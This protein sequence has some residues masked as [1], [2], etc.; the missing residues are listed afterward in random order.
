MKKLLDIKPEERNKVTNLFFQNFFDGLGTSF[1]YAMGIFIFLGNSTHHDALH[2]YPLVFVIGGLLI[3]MVSPVYSKIETRRDPLVYHDELLDYKI[4]KNGNKT[5]EASRVKRM[6]LTA[7]Y[8][9][10]KS[11]N[12]SRSKR[13]A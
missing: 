12:V 3:L 4:E 6:F 10:I 2:Y 7:I 9:F 5:L 13:T 1:F 8:R 11:E